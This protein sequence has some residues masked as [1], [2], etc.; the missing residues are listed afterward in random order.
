M[1]ALAD[2]HCTQPVACT[3]TLLPNESVDLSLNSPYVYTFIFLHHPGEEDILEV[4]VTSSYENSEN[5]M[6]EAAALSLP[7][8]YITG[9][10]FYRLYRLNQNGRSW[11]DALPSHK[12]EEE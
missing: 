5:S 1:Q 6:T 11:F 8:L 2:Y 9:F 3:A 4:K 7:S 10:V 12:W